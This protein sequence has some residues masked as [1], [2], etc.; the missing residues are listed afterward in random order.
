[1]EREFSSFSV[2]GENKST[3]DIDT[4]NK[5]VINRIIQK[6]KKCE[7]LNYLISKLSFS[8]GVHVL[9]YCKIK[10]DICRF[11]YDD[12]RRFAFDQYRPKECQNILFDDKELLKGV[13]KN[14]L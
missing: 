8:K 13:L 5:E 4:N 11:C 3:L 7:N 1:M 9:L 2:F 6:I 10:C 14:G 12:F